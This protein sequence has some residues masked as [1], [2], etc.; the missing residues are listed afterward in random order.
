MHSDDTLEQLLARVQLGDRAAFASLYLATNAKLF[1]ICL[2]ILK[3]RPLA[4]EALQE[5]YVKIWYK[6]DSYYQNRSKPITWMA[7]VAH[8]HAIDRLRTQ[9]PATIE[10]DKVMDIADKNPSPEQNTIAGDQNRKLADC[11]DELNEIHARAVK[12]AYL[13]GYTYE[14]IGANISTPVNTVKTW[15]RRSLLKLKDCMNR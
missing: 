7:R 14:E 9:K 11:L 6:A 5:V 15:V 1:G 12:L 10:L 2:R 3:Q 4:E 8:N 13:D